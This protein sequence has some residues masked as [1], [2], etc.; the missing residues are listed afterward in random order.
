M[1]SHTTVFAMFRIALLL[2]GSLTLAACA[3]TYW[4]FPPGKTLVEFKADEHSCYIGAWSMTDCL[5]EKGYR[6]ISQPEFIEMN[7]RALAEAGKPYDIVAYD[8]QTGKIF[9]GKSNPT[10]G[11][12]TASVEMMGIGSDVSCTGYAEL[13][14]L[15]PG[16]KGSLGKVE[17]L[18]R[19]GRSIKAEF[20][21]ETVR[22]GFGRGVDSNKHAYRFIFGD[23][24]VS[25]DSL[26]AQ[27][28]EMLKKERRKPKGKEA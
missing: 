21:Y 3:Q 24:D 25:P 17:L 27:F 6:Q 18:C 1:M 4:A 11:S 20:V 5:N 15:V 22:S 13:T 2:G 19:D 14:K 28:K 7:Q 12:A 23:L 26:R 9:V 16:G 10:P 8:V